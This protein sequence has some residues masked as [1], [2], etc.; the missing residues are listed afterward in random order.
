MR[1]A[2][3]SPL[4]HSLPPKIYG[5]TER[6]V[7]Y[8]TEE[9]IKRGHQVTLFAHK[10]SK[11]SA[12][13]V[14]IN[15]KNFD[16]QIDLSWNN[17]QLYSL[18]N[19]SAAYQRAEEF[20]IIHNHIGVYPLFFSKLV[21]APTLTTFHNPVCQIIDR[22]D[23]RI[24]LKEYAKNYFVAISK[25][26]RIKL[27][28]ALNY[29]STIYNGIPVEEFEF[30]NNPKDY[31][32]WLGRLNLIKGAKDAILIAKKLKRK[33][34]LAGI[35]HKNDEKIYHT[36]IEPLIDNC[37]IRYI[38][39]VNQKQKIKLLKNAEGLVYPI[40]WDEP[41]GL[42]MVEAMACGTPVVAYKRGS[43]SEVIKDN[44]TGFIVNDLEEMAKK[45][46]KINSIDRYQCRKWVEENFTVK[47]M[48][49][50]YEKIYLQIINKHKKICK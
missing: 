2:Q 42:V 28:P 34:I 15:P 23:S 6:I 41:F 35:I 5:G 39:P 4:W 7:Y 32:V 1:I 11:T 17:Y 30:N 13:L 45:V 18:L 14:G 8:L 37:L 46:K 25:D 22:A 38:G 26:Q 3:I 47:K 49:D 12:K 33:L 40:Q 44:K 21:K 50:N 36:E 48:V 10:D 29:I 16:N 19:T 43:I 31:L 9:L 20:E 27:N 24:A